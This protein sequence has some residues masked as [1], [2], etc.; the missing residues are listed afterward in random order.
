MDEPE[1]AGRLSPT[2]SKPEE[3]R[4]EVE[5][6]FP[7]DLMPTVSRNTRLDTVHRLETNKS[8]RRTTSAQIPLDLLKTISRS[9]TRDAVNR[10]DIIRELDLEAAGHSY[11]VSGP[12]SPTL[13]NNENSGDAKEG[14]LSDK[15]VL[16]FEHNDPENPYCFSTAKKIFIVLTGMLIVVNSA[17]GSSVASGIGSQMTDYFGIDSDTQLVLPTSLYLVGYVLGPLVFSPLS[18]TFG[19]KIVMVSTFILYTGFTLG[20]ALAPTFAGLIVMRLI[21]GIGAS[22]PNSVVGGI[23]ADIFGNPKDRGRVIALYMTCTTFGPLIGPIAS[24]YVGVVSWRWAYWVM[25]IIAG[26]TWPPLLFMPETYGPIVLKKKAQRMRKQGSDVLA[27]TELEKLDIHQMMVVILTR[28]IRM[29]FFEALVLFSCLY[30]ALIYAIFYMF[31]QAFPIIYTGVYG[32]NAGERGLAFLA[33][34]IGSVIAFAIYMSWEQYLAYVGRK[35]VKPSWFHQEEYRRV[36]LACIAAP[37]LVLSMFWLGWTAKP[38]IHWIV[39]MAAGIPFGIAY[40]LVFMALL[41]YIVDAYEI[42]SASAMAAA[43]CSRSM[44]AV[45]LPFAAAPMYNR[46]GIA[47]ACSL[48]GFVGILLGVIPFMFLRYGATI[49]KNSKFCQ[50]LAARKETT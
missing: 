31:L 50:E 26:V 20:C 48:L 27:P 10:A 13:T 16:H 41:N 32:F 30:T 25:L 49:R 29:F 8:L 1:K 4:E 40:L 5:D 21:A 42:F 43:S 7:L 24:G 9:A 38:E 28:P 45:A 47:W 36:P 12:T 23:Y 17:M 19:R 37:L 34:G 22:T 14:D 46:L 33:I 35:P 18:E 11:D 44:L 6:G 3:A 39:P 15:K 2:I